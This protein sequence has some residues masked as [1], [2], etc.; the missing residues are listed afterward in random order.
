MERKAV[1]NVMIFSLFNRIPRTEPEAHMYG[2]LMI[3][4]FVKLESFNKFVLKS[5]CSQMLC[6]D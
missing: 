5:F 1:S 4:I 3:G 2:Y 6:K